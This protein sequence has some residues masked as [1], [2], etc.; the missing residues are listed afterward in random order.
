MS[1]MTNSVNKKIKAVLRK[2]KEYVIYPQIVK[3]KQKIFI[4]GRNKTGT[5][6]LTQEFIEQGF[7]VGNEKMAQ[8][9]LR[10]PYYRDDFEPI[11]KF[12]YTAQVFQDVPF[13]WPNTYIHLDK[14]FPNSKFILSIR[15][16]EQWYN[17]MVNHMARRITNSN[18]IPTVKELKEFRD[19]YYWKSM[20]KNQFAP[21]EEP[22]NKEAQIKSFNAYNRTIIEYF[23]NTG[24]L[25]VLDVSE[26]NDYSRFCN[27]I[28]IHQ[29]KDSFPWK[30]RGVY[31]TT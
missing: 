8:K 5:T 6:S 22:F 24:K 26:V 20:V 25:L 27:F 2:F 15:D 13:S 11:V 4:V 12:C 9:L 18:R 19:G 17:S 28:G 1:I 10:D 23:E 29:I 30:N 14:A 3:G 31:E 21:L 16:P 7:I